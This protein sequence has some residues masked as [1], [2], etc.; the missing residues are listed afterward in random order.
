M[1][2]THTFAFDNA[3]PVTA[4]TSMPAISNPF[5]PEGTCAV[6]LGRVAEACA[7]RSV[8]ADRHA[9]DIS[10]IIAINDPFFIVFS[11]SAAHSRCQ[12]HSGQ[13]LHPLPM[14]N[15]AASLRDSR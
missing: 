8:W 3:S 9:L 12:C 5:A 7:V 13:A 15:T 14:P 2:T 4:F 11:S 1:G 6:S 10:H